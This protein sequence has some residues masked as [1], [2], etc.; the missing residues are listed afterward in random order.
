M[1][2]DRAAGPG[3]LLLVLPSLAAP[4]AAQDAPSGITP[5]TQVRQ[6]EFRFVDTQTLPEETLRQRI[7]LTARGGMVGLRRTFGFLPF[8]TPVGEHPFDPLELGR[9]VVR[10]RNLY[11]DSG[12][13]LAEVRHE[14]RYEAEPDLIDVTYVIDEGDPLLLRN[15]DYRRAGGG[16][17]EIPPAAAEEWVELRRAELGE[18]LRLGQV[19]L[20]GIATR[21]GRWFRHWGFPFA[22]ARAGAAVDTSANRADVTIEIEQGPRSRIRALEVTGNQTVPAR[23][24]TRQLPVRPGDWYDAE[25]LEDGRRQLVQ[26]DLVRLVLVEVSPES[27]DD[28]SV[29]V[30]LAVTENPPNLVSG[31]LGF[32]ADGG[33]S[34]Q[35]EWTNRGFLGGVRTLA[36]AAVAQTGVLALE[37]PQRL[38]RLGAPLFQPY[39]GHRR[40]SVA[41]G[42]FVE[43]RDDVRDRSWALGVDGSLVWAAA[44]LRSVSLTYAFSRRRILEYGFGEDLEPE[45]SLPILGL[46]E[47][48]AVGELERTIRRGVVRLEGS[49]GRLDDFANPRLGFVFRP[50]LELTTPGRFNTSEYLL[51][52]L[53]GSAFLPLSRRVGLALRGAAGRI[54][55]YGKSLPPEGESP[56]L[57]LLRLQDVTFTAG[58]TRDVRGWGSQLLG[59]KLPEVQQESEE[60]GGGFFA[61]RYTPVGG[62]ARL[63]A[64][65]ELRLPLPGFSPEWQTFAFLDGGRV[66]TPDRRFALDA[67][68]LEQ[69]DFF[70]SAG[71][72]ISYRTVVGSVQLAMGYKLNPSALDLRAPEDVLEAL[73]DGRPVTDA[74]ESSGRRLHLHLAI[75]STF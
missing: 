10:L 38:Y 7:A 35:V 5:A 20:Q 1:R 3:L 60:N 75:G 59:P 50:R 28:S 16:A 61:E 54:W 17:T 67:P 63:S 48:G 33:L 36:V 29:V 14:V 6:I 24:L 15:L 73:E 19:E 69:D 32:A 70:A 25:R 44:P 56:F 64:T 58:G 30:R 43:Y 53:G 2:S 18:P 74:E 47:P 4:L 51:A 9:D 46:A 34:S 21:A 57:S 22:T 62:L 52:D 49:Y 45:E 71:V 66:W 26:L 39:V 41:A 31:D 11:H 72:G 55:P 13:P 40:L 8:V 23:H 12:F 27:A 42:P 37:T 68:D 65:A